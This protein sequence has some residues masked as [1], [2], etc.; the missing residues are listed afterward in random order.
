MWSPHVRRHL[1]D[2]LLW[3]IM[4]TYNFTWQF[5]NI[6]IPDWSGIRILTVFCILSRKKLIMQLSPNK[7]VPPKTATLK[8]KIYFQ[9]NDN[10]KKQWTLNYSKNNI[11]LFLNMKSLTL[12]LLLEW[13]KD[14]CSL[15]GQ[16]T[17]IPPLLNNIKIHCFPFYNFKIN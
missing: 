16:N 9:L 11:K 12:T 2:H 14:K 10:A 1:S 6:Q 17:V 3:Y 4:W 13:I 15:A 8:I 7:L 5:T